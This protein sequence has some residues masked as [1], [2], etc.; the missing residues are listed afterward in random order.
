MTSLRLGLVLA[1]SL[2]LA[3]SSAGADEPATSAPRETRASLGGAGRVVV[4]MLGLEMRS[5]DRPFLGADYNAHLGP[6]DF[7]M[8]TNELDNGNR[9]YHASSV[10]FIPSADVFLTTSFSVGGRVGGSV[11][12]TGSD[13]ASGYAIT[14][15]PRLGYA[16][17][18]TRHL[19]LWPRLGGGYDQRRLS[20]GRVFHFS[21]DTAFGEGDLGFIVRLS[22]SALLNAGPRGRVDSSGVHMEARLALQY[23]F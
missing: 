23:D 19:A 11:F 18:I 16:I 2:L 3:A 10:G 9:Q 12:L 7:G 1:T 21:N 5:W 15:A 22:P 6:L 13:D 20:V 8:T 17:P 14:I 4:D